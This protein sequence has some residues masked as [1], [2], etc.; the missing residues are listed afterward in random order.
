ML[1]GFLDS[2]RIFS[3]LW[4]YK[5]SLYQALKRKT[6]MIQFY[7]PTQIV[8]RELA[9]QAEKIYENFVFNDF[10]LINGGV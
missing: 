10:K 1:P 7:E 5:N 6:E 3:Y 2:T 8:S 4:L 9:F